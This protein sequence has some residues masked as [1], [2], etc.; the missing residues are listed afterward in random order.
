MSDREIA[1]GT[2]TFLRKA[3]MK[4]LQRRAPG[5]LKQIGVKSFTI[6]RRS[7]ARRHADTSKTFSKGLV[8]SLV[9]KK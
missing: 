8:K 9:R 4:G 7:V 5:D 2:V 3:R 6:T 1:R